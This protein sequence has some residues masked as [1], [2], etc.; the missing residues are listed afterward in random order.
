MGHKL[1]IKDSSHDAQANCMT[2]PSVGAS[3]WVHGCP[4]DTGI[5]GMQ[6]VSLVKLRG[7]TAKWVNPGL[8]ATSQKGRDKTVQDESCWSYNGVGSRHILKLA[9]EV[10]WH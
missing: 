1:Y 3:S 6:E 9:C 7:P 10:T 8:V 2:V 5:W 4:R